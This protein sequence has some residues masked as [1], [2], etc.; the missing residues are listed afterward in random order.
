[1]IIRKIK[2]LLIAAVIPII[3]MGFVTILWHPLSQAT[4]AVLYAIGV[5]SVTTVFLILALPS[6]AFSS[7]ESFRVSLD[8]L[9]FETLGELKYLSVKSITTGLFI[10][11]VAIIASF[12]IFNQNIFIAGCM[13]FWILAGCF[14]IYMSS[15]RPAYQKNNMTVFEL[16]ERKF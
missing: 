14:R 10:A 2:I 7:I 13:G 3:V 6:E 15:Q 4:I 5:S 12:Y 9:I 11:A 16:V 1:M 8:E